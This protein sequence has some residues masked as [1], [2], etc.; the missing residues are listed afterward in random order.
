MQYA[1]EK[2]DGK[3]DVFKLTAQDIP[4]SKIGTLQESLNLA[5]F[6]IQPDKPKLP[7]IFV[8]DDKTITETA[9]AL[10]RRNCKIDAIK[11]VRSVT[12]WDL[13]SAKDFC[14]Q[15][16]EESGPFMVAS[17]GSLDLKN[18]AIS[19]GLSH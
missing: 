11:F 2:E 17:P 16:Y 19:R 6:E 1:I 18:F 13:R 7:S 3:F 15:L 5:L 12:A 4:S 8:I 10:Y 14:D 9:A